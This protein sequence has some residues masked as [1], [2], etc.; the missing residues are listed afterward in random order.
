M[1]AKNHDKTPTELPSKEQFKNNE[2]SKNNM[3]VPYKIRLD[4]L[5]S[6]LY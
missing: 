4:V 1:M 3:V 5:L 6:Q 2:L